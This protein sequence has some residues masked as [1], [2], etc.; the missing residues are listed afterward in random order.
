MKRHLTPPRLFTVLICALA[1]GTPGRASDALDGN[2][3]LKSLTAANDRLVEQALARTNAGGGRGAGALIMTMAAAYGNPLSSLHRDPRLVPAMDNLVAT[4]RQSQNPSGLWSLGNIDSPPDSSFILKTLAK[5]Q[6]FLTRDNHPPT[7]ALRSRLRELILSCVEGVRTGG[8][9]TP[10]HRWAVCTALAHVNALYPDAKYVERIDEWLAEGVDV[11]ADGQWAERSSNYTS[12]VN[13]PS[14]VDLALLLKRPGLLDPVRRSLDASLYFF[15]PDGEVETVASRRQDQRPNSR[16]HV[17]EYYFPYRYLAI[18]DGNGTYAAVARWIEKEFLNELGEAASNMSS[19][20]TVMLEYPEMTRPL[21]PETPLPGSYAKVFP[22][23]SLARIKRGAV[24]ATVYGGS[25]WYEG[26]GHGSGIATNPTFFKFRKGEAVLESV[27]MAP[28]FFSTGFFYSQGLEVS[29]REYRLRQELKVPYHQPLPKERRRADGQYPLQP[30]MGTENVLARYFSRMD[31]ANRPKQFVTLDNKVTAVERDDGF[32][33][34]FDIG[35]EPGV[36]VTI[37]LTF[38]QGGTLDGVE[39]RSAAGNPGSSGAGLNRG[40]PMTSA[41]LAGTHVL[42]SGH[43]TYMFGNDRITFGPGSLQRPP[44]RLE[45]ESLTWVSGSM[46]TTGER[47]YLTGTTPF[48]HTL[49]FR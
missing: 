12:D 25:D 7:E 2:A 47:V 1:L 29:G 17:W 19:P 40:G 38:R 37:E 34:V 14:M 22:L 44:G 36:A 28:S 30:D 45:G 21:P 43:A 8:V 10:N 18:L 32:D 35:G 24:T 23:S 42:R 3:I 16:K 39:S 15:E 31:F 13:N 11:D 4:L 33:L 27:R 26:L 49:E 9:H 41:D 6:L 20:L 5:G 46:R 48:R